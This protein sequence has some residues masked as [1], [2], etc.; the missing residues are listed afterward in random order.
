MDK[1]LYLG[2]DVSMAENT[3]CPLL[4][5]GTEARR[6]FTVP[7]NLPG[8]KQLVTEILML[9]EQYHLDRLLVG[10]EAT[11]LYWWHLACFLNSS[12]EISHFQ[13]KV[14]AFNPRLIKGF[15]KALADISKS[16]I[17]DAYAITERLR[18][19]R[20]PAPFIPNELYQPLQRLT[21]FRCHLMHQITREKNYFLSFL[22]LKFSE[23]Q[24]LDPLS[25]TFGAASQAVLTDYFTVD[26]IVATPLEELAQLLARE[27]KNH[28]PS[29]ETVAAVVKRAARDS[30]RPHP[31]LNEPLNLI[32]SATLENIRT[33]SQQI[34][35]VDQAIE[36][37]VRKFPNP[38]SSIPGLGPVFTAGIMAEIQDISRFPDQASLAKY[39][40]LFWRTSESGSFQAEET[41]LGKSGN[42]YLRYYLIEATNSVR[43]HNAE[44][45]R[46]YQ[47]KY[48]ESTKHKHKRALVLTARKLVRLVDAMLRHNQLYIP[49]S[50]NLTEEVNELANTK[51]RPAKQH[52][53]RQPG[54]RSPVLCA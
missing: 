23:Y 45:G 9:M 36:R 33:L 50:M 28:F 12:R 25:D 49:P 6:R 11:N 41:S 29:P 16:D 2:I 5:D 43:M 27:G 47:A 14:Y 21:R 52:H 32:L 35:K 34:K 3:C 42:D 19:G 38:L 4:Q 7:N 48:N 13:P 37:E 10:L 54:S 8:A 1:T 15:K 22:F 18:F 46:Y 51:A 30:Y 53:Y 24:N 40:G 20:L 44:Y 39:A 31:A 17:N 26:E